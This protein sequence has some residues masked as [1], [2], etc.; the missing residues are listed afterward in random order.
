LFVS[1][2]M[3]AIQS[4]C[5]RALYISGGRLAA[6]GAPDGV[7]SQY[8]SLVSEKGSGG[9]LTNHPGRLAGG[10]HVFKR[11]QF[12]DEAGAARTSFPMG[13]DLHVRVE[14]DLPNEIRLPIIGLGFRS[15][16]GHMVAIAGSFDR[17][18][19]SLEGKV[20]LC[21][22]IPDPR[23]AAGDYSVVVDLRSDIRTCVD[24]IEDAARLSIEPRDLWGTG[25][26][27]SD[28]D[29]CWICESSWQVAP[30]AVSVP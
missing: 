18:L 15:S 27:P 3:N 7:I 12:L 13:R 19:P 20:T 23:L 25:W 5:T 28:Q 30:E 1:H 10:G 14:L 9:D 29:R 21:G 4:L 11:L 26:L 6:Q 2:N 8:L 16:G 22:T 24:R 17:V